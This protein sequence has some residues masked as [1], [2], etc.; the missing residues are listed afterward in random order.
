M[1]ENRDGILSK[2]EWLRYQIIVWKYPVDENDINEIMDRYDQLVL[3]VNV[4]KSDLG[5]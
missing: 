2:Y 1:D 4:V 3:I 5:I